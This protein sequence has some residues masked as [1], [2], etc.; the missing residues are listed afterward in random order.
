MRSPDLSRES[1]L[2]VTIDTLRP[3]RL[4]SYGYALAE[5]PHL[6]ALAEGGVRFAEVYSS[7]P[8][9]LPSHATMFTG[10]EPFALG[11]R[12]N[13]VH[14][15]PPSHRTLAALLGEQGF[16]TFAAVAAY[17]VTSKFGLAQ[18]FDVYDDSLGTA[19]LFQDFDS[20]IPAD[21]VIAKVERWLERRR[22][23]DHRPFFAWVH[24]YDPHLPYAPP[25]ELATRFRDRP[26]DGE[27]AFVDAQVGRLLEAFRARGLLESTLVVVTSDHG[28]AFGEHVEQG[29]G[30]LCYEEV[31]RVPL[32]FAA[33]GRIPA[34]HVVTER[35]RLVD[36][37][38]TLLE[39]L[40]VEPPP[41]LDGR[42]F[43]SLLAGGRESRP[44]DVYFESMNGAE[45]KNWAPLQ[46]ILVDR[47]KYIA[48]PRPELYDLG[49]D[50]HERR[51][52]ASLRTAEA[53]R[54][55]RELR[56]LLPSAPEPA[57]SRRELTGEDESRL[58]A[59]GYLSLSASSAGE[60][61][62]PK[63]G[64]VLEMELHAVRTSLE[65]GEVELAWETLERLTA[66]NP[67][68]EMPEIVELRHEL[69]A[70][71]GDPEAALAV[72]R[73]GIATFPEVEPL[74]F[75]LA[76]YLVELERWDEAEAVGFALLEANPRMSQALNL[77]GAIAERREDL[78][79]AIGFYERGL[80]LEPGSIP[81]RARLADT[82]ARQD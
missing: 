1:L 35:V 58:R 77:L 25:G 52:L 41:N 23:E 54:L 3:D 69:A 39:L 10:K 74:R 17:V 32:L 75:K 70:A 26:Y 61:L 31:L 40:G 33:P 43:A 82:L 22:G 7:V 81:L 78:P 59:L 56:R 71:Q 65:G 30:L 15:L 53:E 8:L 14:F 79:A 72:L 5:T 27:I 45:F 36:L 50:P 68:L 21:R 4:G 51:N 24:L 62:D 37:L 48:L 47:L 63:R 38:P 60:P 76:S 46:G 80:E 12:V 2:L 20:E 28:E 9:T 6:D 13:G 55:R 64:I 66:E 67:D 34:G 19:D 57:D 29:H 18:G 11:V 44:R 16:A 42:S 49:A 73:G